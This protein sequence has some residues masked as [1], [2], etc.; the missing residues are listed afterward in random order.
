MGRRDYWF[1]MFPDFCFN[2]IV[3]V[4][5]ETDF[6]LT[7]NSICLGAPA[8]HWES[9]NLSSFENMFI[10]IYDIYN[11]E[12][13]H[14]ISKLWYT[15]IHP[16]NPQFIGNHPSFNRSLLLRRPSQATACDA[17]EVGRSWPW[18]HGAM[19]GWDLWSTRMYPILMNDTP[20][21]VP[22]LFWIFSQNSSKIYLV[23]IG[24]FRVSQILEPE[25]P[26]LEP[27]LEPADGAA[28]GEPTW[29]ISS[30]QHCLVM[31]FLVV[32]NGW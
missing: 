22:Y 27:Q 24:T 25:P 15:V 11:I 9:P 17:L 30:K 12:Y 18:G 19:A 1:I 6:A 20:S 13:T 8:I 16:S 29:V 23:M 32:S 26:Q 10:Y 28:A 14:Q 5:N 7:H 4:I 3:Y 21:D 2:H 31:V